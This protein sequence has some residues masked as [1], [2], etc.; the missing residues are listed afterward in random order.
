M[1]PNDAVSAAGTRKQR[2][3]ISLLEPDTGRGATVWGLMP[4]TRAGL[5]SATLT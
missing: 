5:V 2:I 1:E 4:Q 3:A